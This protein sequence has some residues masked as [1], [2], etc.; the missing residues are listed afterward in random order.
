MNIVENIPAQP[1]AIAPAKYFH[2]SQNNNGG[3]F[4]VSDKVAHHVFIQARSAAEAN[5]LAGDVG[6]YFNGCESGADCDCCGDRW[7]EV[8]DD[9]GGEMP[10]IYGADPA[11]YDDLFTEPG[12]PV[13]HVYHLDGSKTTYR[14]PKKEVK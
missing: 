4:D 13:C 9:E 1:K 8:W 12:Q 7:S 11:T 6:I 14:K 2:F 10:L 3:S 5:R